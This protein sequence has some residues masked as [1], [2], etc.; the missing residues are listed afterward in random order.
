MI[1][2]YKVQKNFYNKSKTYCPTIIHTH[3][4][5]YPTTPIKFPQFTPLKNN[6]ILRKSSSYMSNT[7]SSRKK[8]Q[9]K[10]Q[11]A[12]TKNEYHR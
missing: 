11:H 1:N 2:P 5:Y 9:H 10:P 3:I 6:T 7:M 8:Q 12:N 4:T